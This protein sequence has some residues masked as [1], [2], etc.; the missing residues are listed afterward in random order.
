MIANKS[1]K[2]YRFSSVLI[3][4]ESLT[5]NLTPS[6]LWKKIRLLFP[7]PSSYLYIESRNS[8][9]NPWLQIQGK[10]TV[11]GYLDSQRY[12]TYSS[13][14]GGRIKFS[15][16]IW[17][18]WAGELFRGIAQRRNYVALKKFVGK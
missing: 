8:R 17:T 2:F 15:E 18:M 1:V 7:M 13:G 11:N 14:K 4:R 12:E 10:T 16:F 6:Y 9:K 5:C 3:F